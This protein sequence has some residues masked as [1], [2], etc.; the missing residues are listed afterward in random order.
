M[1]ELLTNNLLLRT[2]TRDDLDEI[3]G[4]W[5]YMYFELREDESCEKKEENR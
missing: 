4:M 3:A 2:L 5:K 1:I